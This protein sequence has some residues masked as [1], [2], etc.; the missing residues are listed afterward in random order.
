MPLTVS[1]TI[2]VAITAFI[3]GLLVLLVGVLL[4][5]RDSIRRSDELFQ[6]LISGIRPELGA[7]VGDVGALLA[8]HENRRAAE[9]T[10]LRENLDAMRADLEWLTGERMIEQAIQMCRDGHSAK[11]VSHQTGL[12]PEAVRTLNLLRAH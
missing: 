9:Q 10:R 5:W 8:D 2:M 7:H 3:I 1:L 11:E 4:G 12:A 6:D